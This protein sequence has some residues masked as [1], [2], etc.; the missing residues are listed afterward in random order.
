MYDIPIHLRTVILGATINPEEQTENGNTE[1]ATLIVGDVEGGM[2]DIPI[3]LRT[4]ISD[5]ILDA[6]LHTDKDDK[7]GLEI[8][9]K[10]APCISV[11]LYTFS[12]GAGFGPAIYTWTSELFPSKLKGVGSSIALAS[13]NVVVFIILKFYPSM[14]DDLGLSKI[15]WLHAGVMLIG[16]IFVFFVMPETRGLTMTQ[17]NEIFGGKISYQKGNTYDIESADELEE[18]LTSSKDRPRRESSRANIAA[19]RVAATAAL[20]NVASTAAMSR[21]ASLARS[22]GGMGKENEDEYDVKLLKQ[23]S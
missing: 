16:N 15:F 2:Y 7:D 10:M 19:S 21:V 9:I 5:H 18:N 17:L 20:S 6:N 22:V 8:I 4:N 12:Y 13:R 1:N 11:V 14:I 3:H 23:Q